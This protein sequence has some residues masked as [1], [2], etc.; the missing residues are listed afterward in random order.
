MDDRPVAGELGGESKKL[1]EVESPSS[2]TSEKA[3]A[4]ENRLEKGVAL[5]LF[6]VD[7]V[8]LLKEE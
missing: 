4:R 6:L 8:L 5:V 1:S 3:E 7:W 2:S